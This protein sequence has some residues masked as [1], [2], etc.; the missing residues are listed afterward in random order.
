MVA[1][2]GLNSKM[3]ALENF[4]ISERKRAPVLGSAY[5]FKWM[6]KE[7]ANYIKTVENG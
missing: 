5:P 4:I 7:E 1:Q 6:S 2:Y 3:I